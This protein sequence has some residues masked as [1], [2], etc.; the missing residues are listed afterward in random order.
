[1]ETLTGI[2]RMHC[3]LARKPMDRIPVFESFWPDTWTNW[4]N[5]GHITKK[6]DLTT[7]FG[8]DLRQA[9]YVDTMADID[10]KPV[11]LEE[12]DE[13]YVMKDGNGN[14]TRRHKLHDTTPEHISNFVVDRKTWEEFARPLY[15]N[16]DPRRINIEEYKKQRELAR[17]Q[18][19]FFTPCP[20]LM[21]E[22]MQM[23]SNHENLLVGMALD[24]D[25][26]KDM[27]NVFADLLINVLEDSFA[28][29]GMPDGVFFYEDMGFKEKSFFS[30]AMYREII[31]PGHKKVF[32]FCKSHKLPIIMHSCGFVENLIPDLLDSGLQCLQAMEVKAGM[33]VRR[34]YQN[35]G[36]RLSFM[37]GLDVREIYCNDLQR[38][39]N[40][41]QSVLPV[42]MPGNGYCLHTDHSIPPDVTYETYEYYLR[43]AKEIGTYK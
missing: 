25:W 27:V 31:Q 22:F 13:T 10:F 8:F 33:D 12:T 35:F 34:L 37:G 32:D 21:F 3:Q 7:R 2:E 1:M 42:V 20:C 18:N 9:W 40:L 38:V 16:Y 41:L 43:R 19:Q 30:P 5:A 6:E 26:V 39:E 23:L 24:P 14:V 17:E 11:I 29:G 4:E 15:V 28:R 36:D